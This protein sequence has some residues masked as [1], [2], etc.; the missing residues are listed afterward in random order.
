MASHASRKTIGLRRY[1]RSAAPGG[2][3]ERRVCDY[4]AEAHRE[5]R[6]DQRG[7]TPGGRVPRETGA[8]IDLQRTRGWWSLGRHPTWTET[9]IRFPVPRKTRQGG[10]CYPSEHYHTGVRNCPTSNSRGRLSRDPHQRG[11]QRRTGPQSVT[12]WHRG[13][14]VRRDATT[15]PCFSSGSGSPANMVRRF[16]QSGRTGFTSL[17]CAR[18][19]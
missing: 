5:N 11:P 3:R 14:G 12:T 16:Q 19:S 6:V 17:S 9:T 7:T 8:H 10:L 15:A 1:C 13:G 2:L 4:S 18:G